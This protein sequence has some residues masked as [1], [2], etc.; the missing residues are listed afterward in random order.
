MGGEFQDYVMV[1]RCI[2]PALR[3]PCAQLTSYIRTLYTVVHSDRRFVL[4]SKTEAIVRECFGTGAAV[5][6]TRRSLGHH[7]LHLQIL[8]LL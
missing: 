6:Q 5:A 2:V 3:R 7:L 1:T 4:K 8:R